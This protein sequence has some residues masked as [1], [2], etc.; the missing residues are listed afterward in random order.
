M[1]IQLSAI[2]AVIAAGL[3]WSTAGI[4]G[5]SVVVSPLMLAEIRLG[6]AAV[7]LLAF[8]GIPRTTAMLKQTSWPAVLG[9]VFGMGAFQWSYFTAVAMT[10]AAFATW[11]SVA[12]GPLWAA[13]IA[14][15][16]HP[17]PRHGLLQWAAVCIALVFM[18]MGGDVSPVG[19]LY[20]LA[21]GLA[22]AI[23][24]VAANQAAANSSD[25]GLRAEGSLAVTGLAL[26]GGALAM[27]P[28]AWP[29]FAQTDIS[30]LR[31]LDLGWLAFL[32]LGS[33]ALAYFLFG[34]GVS[35]L[36]AERALSLQWIQPIATELA[37]VCTPGYRPSL[38]HFVGVTILT[39]TLLHRSHTVEGGSNNYTNYSKC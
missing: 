30:Q 4:I 31:I 16:G 26:F 8:V 22:Y 19:L 28:V 24:A 34:Q 14:G 3:L 6:V 18:M 27:L 10:G 17:L 25:S 9:A 36:T 37:G 21:A 33:T 11:I 20:S 29:A 32:G 5:E 35:Q 13:T 39:A 2:P 15:I 38:A 12:T 1:S 7:A 23:F